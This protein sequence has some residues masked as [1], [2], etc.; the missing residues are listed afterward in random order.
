MRLCSCVV[1]WDGNFCM[2]TAGP[3]FVCTGYLRWA[4]VQGPGTE[5]HVMISVL[6]DGQCL[7]INSQG[8]RRNREL[9]LGE[10]GSNSRESYL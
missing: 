10:I 5:L 1:V 2:V 6:L 9:P 8:T 7:S 3:T 4:R